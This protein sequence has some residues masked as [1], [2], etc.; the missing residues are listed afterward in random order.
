LINRDSS[1]ATTAQYNAYVDYLYDNYFTV[2]EKD[3][4]DPTSNNWVFKW[5]DEYY[6]FGLSSSI[7]NSTP[8]LEQT[9]GWDGLNGAGTFDPLP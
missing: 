3:D 8:Y 1:F 6:Y 9:K 4:L 5:F 2:S 7:L